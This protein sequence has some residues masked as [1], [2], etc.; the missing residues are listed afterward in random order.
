MN[1]KHKNP[2]FG[3]SYNPQDMKGKLVNTHTKIIVD[4]ISS[5][6]STHGFR[7]FACYDTLF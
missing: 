6:K 3:Y 5:Q 2:V 1:Q 7:H 4:P